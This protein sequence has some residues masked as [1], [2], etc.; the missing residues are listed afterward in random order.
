MSLLYKDGEFQDKE[1]AD[2]AAEMY[3]EGHSFF[4]YISDSPDSLSSCCRLSN[5]IQENTFTFTNGLTGEQT[6]S[7]SVITLNYNRIMQNFVN[8][9]YGG[10]RNSW[11]ENKEEFEE[12]F[13]AYLIPILERVYKYHTA[14]NEILWDLY[15]AKMLPVYSAGFINLNRQYLTIGINGLNEAYMFLGGECR[16]NED[17]QEFCKM[18]TG[19]MKEQNTLHRTRK[20]MFNSEFVPAESLGIKNYKWDKR[21]GYVVPEGRNCYTSYFFLPDDDRVSV[22]EKM[23]LHGKDFVSSCDGGSACHINLKEHL[24]KK[25]YE[26]LLKFAGEHGTNYF[27]FNVKNTEC[28]DCGYISKHTIDKCPHCGSTNLSYWTRIIG[29]LRRVEDFNEGRQIEEGKRIYN[30]DEK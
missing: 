24:S 4:T 15:E 12:K 22:L 17:Y 30:A 21:D 14:Y 29:Y 2:F 3:A 8:E 9:V 11:K 7:K 27:T 18:I 25:Q 20:T 1:Y 23:E 6:G 16:Y 28:K 13:K 19:T 26:T 10:N 5:K